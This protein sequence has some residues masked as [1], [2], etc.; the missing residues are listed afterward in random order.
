[1]WQKCR[2]SETVVASVLCNYC[3]ATFHADI[4][5]YDSC[6]SFWQKLFQSL[7]CKLKALFLCHI[8]LAFCSVQNQNL[9]NFAFIQLKK[10]SQYGNIFALRV[11]QLTVFASSLHPQ[12]IRVIFTSL[13]SA[14]TRPNL[15]YFHFVSAFPSV[16]N[17][18]SLLH[19]HSTLS[20]ASLS[21]SEIKVWN[22]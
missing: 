9:F 11:K 7:R 15:L 20:L 16:S 8:N 10:T 12:I 13:K 18:P 1:M 19:L 3:S 21:L 5:T 17:F 14:P 6:C 22:Q 2:S 4:S